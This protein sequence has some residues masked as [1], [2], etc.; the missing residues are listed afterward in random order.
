[1]ICGGAKSVSPTSAT[2]S[3]RTTSPSCGRASCARRTCGTSSTGTPPSASSSTT[4]SATGGARGRWA[5][6]RPSFC[7]ATTC[8]R[9]RTPNSRRRSSSCRS[10]TRAFA[11]RTS[12]GRR[13]CRRPSIHSQAPSWSPDEEDAHD[14]SPHVR[15][16]PW[17]GGGGSVPAEA[18]RRRR[19]A[20]ARDES[21]GRSRLP[22]HVTFNANNGNMVGPWKIII[23]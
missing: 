19:V 4:W 21:R 8:S 5:R 14:E 12:G 23:F 20:G 11:S 1:M 22:T 15:V 18:L 10:R 17:I 13:S 16:R 6:T 2:H 9:P 3:P 7:V